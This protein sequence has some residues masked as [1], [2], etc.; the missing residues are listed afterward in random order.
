M[1]DKAIYQILSADQPLRGYVSTYR[2]APAIFSGHAPEDVQLPFIVFHIT[3]SAVDRVVHSFNVMVDYFDYNK[4]RA[5]SEAAAERVEYLLDNK[6][7]Q[8]DR[9]RDVRIVYFAGSPVPNSGDPRDV[10]YNVQFSARGI[11]KKW[12]N[13]TR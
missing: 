12:M 3:P 11:R 8:S 1:F 7:I 6:I 5:A 9:Y 4:S 13:E 10:Q 2:N